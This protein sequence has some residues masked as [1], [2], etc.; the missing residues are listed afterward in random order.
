MGLDWVFRKGDVY[1]AIL[2]NMTLLESK[3]VFVS[4]RTLG[5]NTP[6]ITLHYILLYFSSR[7]VKHT[8]S[9][10]ILI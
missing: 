7:F 3:L 5:I 9:Y 6:I 10:N 2:A 1:M 8:V 4:H